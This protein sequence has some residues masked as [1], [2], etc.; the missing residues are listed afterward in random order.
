MSPFLDLMSFAMLFRAGASLLVDVE[1]E[2][3]LDEGVIT[4]GIEVGKVKAGYL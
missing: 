3:E 1:A 2:P 4:E